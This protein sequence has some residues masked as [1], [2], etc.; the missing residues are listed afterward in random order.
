MLKS[1]STLQGVTTLSKGDQR[2]IVGGLVRTSC[3]CTGSVGA[4]TY[5]TTGLVPT[6]VA[7]RDIQTYCASGT[8]HC[9]AIA[10]NQA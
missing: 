4:W 3:S 2:K 6:S 7:I 1:I 8:G 10:I 9:S 5:D